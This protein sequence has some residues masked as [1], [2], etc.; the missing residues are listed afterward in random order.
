MPQVYDENRP[1]ESTV[2]P[3]LVQKAVVED[4]AFSN[5]PRARLV[6]NAY[7][8]IRWDIDPEMAAQSYI[9]RSVMACDPRSG[10]HPR[11]ID[12][13]GQIANGAVLF[14]KLCGHR[15][16]CTIRFMTATAIV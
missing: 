6:R 9:R 12:E 5:R 7:P 14:D 11:E 15:T 16:R 10:C 2:V 1:R 13:T 8:A 4:E 3:R